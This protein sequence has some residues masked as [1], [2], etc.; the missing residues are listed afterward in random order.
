[1]KANVDGAYQEMSSWPLESVSEMNSL[2]IFM[3][4]F[5][6]MRVFFVQLQYINT[7]IIQTL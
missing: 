7:F 1:M 6:F 3:A 5:T 2:P 4:I